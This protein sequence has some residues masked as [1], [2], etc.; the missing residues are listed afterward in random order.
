M[1]AKCLAAID[2]LASIFMYA[3]LICVILYG[4]KVWSA[5]PAAMIKHR[6]LELRDCPGARATISYNFETYGNWYGYCIR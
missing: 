6:P 3:A 5:E 4:I 2:R 1:C